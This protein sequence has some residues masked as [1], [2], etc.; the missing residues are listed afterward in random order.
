MK[1]LLKETIEELGYHNK[2]L[3]DIIFITSEPFLRKHYNCKVN[4][5][6]LQRLLDVDYDNGFGTEEINPDLKLV[7]ADFW[8]ER[9]NY[10]GSEWWEFKEL[11]VYKEELNHAFDKSLILTR[12]FIDW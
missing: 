7:G 11:P 10:D 5:E 3:S 1:N 2:T 8:L 9:H 4:E 12:Q 6:Q